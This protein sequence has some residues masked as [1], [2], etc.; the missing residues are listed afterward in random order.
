M[1]S[2]ITGCSS[3]SSWDADKTRIE[4]A[5]ERLS[6]ALTA[7]GFEVVR[8]YAR[9]YREEDC[10]SSFEVMGSC[11]ANNPAAPYVLFDVQ[12]WSDEDL[13]PATEDVFGK[14][15]EGHSTTFRLDPRE[16]I[17]VLGRMPP[18]A[19][20]YG[21]QTYLFTREGTFKTASVPYLYLSENFDGALLPV[22]FSEVPRNDKRIQ[23]FASLGNS[24]NHVVVQNRAES[25]F[26]ADRYFIVTP[27]R[28]MDTTVR[29]AFGTIGVD[30]RHV[31]TESIPSEARVGL[32]A[33][34][35][36]F[37]LLM[38]YA[39]P[40][41][42]D[43]EGS[44]GSQWR[45]ALPLTVLRVRDRS[46]SRPPEPHGPAQIDPRVAESELGPQLEADLDTLLVEVARRWGQDCLTPDCSDRSRPFF[47]LQGDEHFNLV[48][49][50][51]I[52]IGMNCLADTQDTTYM[53]TFTMPIDRGEVYAIA[54]T[55][56]TRTGNATYVGLSVNE[57]RVMKGIANVS[58]DE[59]ADTASAYAA[60]LNDH[61]QLF[62]HYFARDCGGLTDLTD[63]HCFTV[64]A[65]MV[66][67]CDDY[68]NPDCD[69]LKL[70]QRQYIKPGTERG[71][72]SQLLLV[73]RM[74]PLQRPAIP[75]D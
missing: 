38:R 74:L 16:A 13:D 23:L 45:E 61:S 49:P 66:G 6:E 52:E 1:P 25:A 35:D 42:G 15:R 9:L 11:Y 10:D 28:F 39:M 33:S 3:G 24:N 14:P 36:D 72:D 53:N 47:D 29:Q 46:P 62:L 30:D 75:V 32:A 65:D 55:L 73:P 20:Y 50:A 70:V 27:D 19:A 21:L 34:A 4:E 18:P 67:V 68:G 17:V 56:A 31:F 71:P 8:G 60:H 59:L 63:G 57:T 7:Q 48:G 37:V 2:L 54:G 41:G 40:V 69:Q 26:D 58:S 5:A 22:F 44:L 51:C 43:G 12:Y 64:D